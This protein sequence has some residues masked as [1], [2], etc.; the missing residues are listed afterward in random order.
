[1]AVP[2]KRLTKRRIGNR[3]SQGHGKIEPVNR[4]VCSNCGASVKPHAVCNNCGF[5]KGKKIFAKLAS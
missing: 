3:R 2:K 1:M 5:Y 4:A